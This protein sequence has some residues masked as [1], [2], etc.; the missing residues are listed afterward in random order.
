[1]SEQ[2]EKVTELQLRIREAGDY[3]NI[4]ES[5]Q[6]K[7]VWKSYEQQ[8][9]KQW[10]AAQTSEEREKVW[11]TLQGAL[12]VVSAFKSKVDDGKIAAKQLDN[13]QKEK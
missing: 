2:F 11:F 1:M 9:T 8:L 7:N 5:E 4:Y 3:K 10:K 13:I 6:F 12:G